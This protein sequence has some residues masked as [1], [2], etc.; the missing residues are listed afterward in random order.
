VAG[1]PAF[2]PG[3]AHGIA[4]PLAFLSIA[5]TSG[6]A[7]PG[8]TEAIH[9]AAAWLHRWQEPTGSWP[10]SI[11]GDD[12]DTP[13]EARR[14][15]PGR[16]DAW[17]YGAAGIGRALTLAGQA[18]ADP[19]LGCSGLAT[20]TA[21]ADRDPSQWD[22]EGPT[23]CHGSAGILQAAAKNQC[24]ALARHAAEHTISL[25]NPHRPFSF[26]HAEAGTGATLDNPGFLTGAAGTALALAD[27]AG[28]LP[29]DPP[30]PWD[31]LLLLT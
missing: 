16:R 14:R 8:Q 2:G 21:L 19:D 15:P 31:S 25:H 4:G 12:L 5:H 17:C 10:P 6:R 28:L 20:I 27:H 22:T 24:A 1:Q 18:L 26:P 23:L 3:L 11:S 30:T 29:P 13:P 7:V 9:T